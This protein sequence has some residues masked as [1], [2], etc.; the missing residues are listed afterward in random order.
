[1]AK[2]FINIIHI[3]SFTVVQEISFTGNSENYCIS[4]IDL[5]D[6][7]RNTVIT[8]AEKMKRY[9]SVFINIMSAIARDFH[10]NIIKNTGDSIIYYF[11]ETS[12][13]AN[14]P[15]F[16][17]V[18]ECGL[19]MIAVNPI[20]NSKLNDEGVPSLDYRIS[21]D[22]G[23][24]DVAK[25]LTSTSEDLFGPTVNICSKINSMASPNSMV[26][27]GDL[28]KIV[29]HLDKNYYFNKVGEYSLGDLG[30]QY[31]VYCISSKSKT[32]N[33]ETLNLYK[34]IL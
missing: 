8:D 4:F 21:A 34:N 10:S 29:K 9:Y 28:Y 20:I 3:R 6:S 24:V 25:S 13:S 31:P 5:V 2:I 1:M 27:G 14:V 22:Y 19:T 16:K 30:I 26:M 12:D 11:P 23:R 18:L 33:T 17:R 32:S 15:A 7:T